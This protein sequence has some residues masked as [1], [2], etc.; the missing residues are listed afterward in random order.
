[1][2]RVR[3]DAAGALDHFKRVEVAV[4]AKAVGVDRLVGQ[5]QHVEQRIEMAHRGVDVGWLDRIA[6]P[7][8]HAVDALAEPDKIAEV[9]PVAGPASAVAVKAVG[10][11]ANRAESGVIAADGQRAGGI[12]RMQGEGFWRLADLRFDQRRVKAH[13]L[14]ASF[15][16]GAGVFQNGARFLVQHIKA[17]FGKHPQ[18]G[19]VD[20]LELVRRDSGHR[21]VGV[22][23]LR[24]GGLAGQGQRPLGLAPALAAVLARLG[25]R[26]WG[27]LRLGHGRPVRVI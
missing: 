11:A 6:A 10:G 22:A 9:A 12:A 26:A 15:D 3:V 21:R 17:D 14:R 20:R 2:Q 13:A 25:W 16:I 1:M 24:S 4:A 23:G 5:G 18:R 19:A 8:M 7:Q 27:S